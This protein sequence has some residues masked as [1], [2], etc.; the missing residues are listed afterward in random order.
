MLQGSLSICQ[1]VFAA[2]DQQQQPLLGTTVLGTTGT[3][4]VT[5]GLKLITATI[6]PVVRPAHRLALGRTLGLTWKCFRETL[7]YYSYELL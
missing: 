5:S 7:C 2:S 4:P 1:L 6:P 3:I